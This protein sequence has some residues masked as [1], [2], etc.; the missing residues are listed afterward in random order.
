M[1]CAFA[2]ERRVGTAVGKADEYRA[3]AEECDR[4]AAAARDRDIKSQLEAFAQQWRIM[5]QNA[6][7]GGAAQE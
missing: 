3:K 5:A 6:E 2:G 7:R 1:T 4:L